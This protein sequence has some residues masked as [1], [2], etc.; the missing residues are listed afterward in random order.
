MQL[1]N[2]ILGGLM[3]MVVGIGAWVGGF[4]QHDKVTQRRHHNFPGLPPKAMIAS[5]WAYIEHRSQRQLRRDRRRQV[6]H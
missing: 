5:S 2:R 3:G 4:F 1:S 6:N